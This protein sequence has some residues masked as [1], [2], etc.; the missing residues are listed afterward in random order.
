MSLNSWTVAHLENILMWS[1][2]NLPARRAASCGCADSSSAVGDSAWE[3]A[4]TSGTDHKAVYALRSDVVHDGSER[5]VGNPE[6]TLRGL[7]LAGR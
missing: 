4:F 1:Q 7:V 5:I 2:K 6:V 3:V